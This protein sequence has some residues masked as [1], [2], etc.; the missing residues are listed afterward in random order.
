MTEATLPC[1]VCGTKLETAFPSPSDE[2]AHM[3]PSD[4]VM[5]TTGGNYGSKVFDPMYERLIF[6]VC[7]QCL[8][9][10]RERAMLMRQGRPVTTYVPWT[11]ENE[12]G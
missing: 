9:K 8:S 6:L 11:D 1:F 5:C 12:R 3:Q 10:R 4:A 7:D 2:A